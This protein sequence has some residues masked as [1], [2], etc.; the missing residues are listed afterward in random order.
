VILNHIY[1]TDNCIYVNYKVRNQIVHTRKT[2][3][4]DV[5]ALL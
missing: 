3:V 4:I 5:I 2:T 1:V